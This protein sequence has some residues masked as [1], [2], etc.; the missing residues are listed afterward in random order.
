MFVPRRVAIRFVERFQPTMKT[1]RVMTCAAIVG[2]V[3]ITAH[4]GVAAAMVAMPDSSAAGVS[5]AGHAPVVLVQYGGNPNGYGDGNQNG[6]SGSPDSQTGMGW[7][8]GWPGGWYG[9]PGWYGDPPGQPR[10]WSSQWGG[11]WYGGWYQPYWGEGSWASPNWTYGSPS[12]YG[13]YPAPSACGPSGCAQEY[14][15]LK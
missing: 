11:G 5:G 3:V 8:G 2:S 7:R 12:Y 15:P 10:N 4:A 9:R 1:L 13:H 14:T 6:W